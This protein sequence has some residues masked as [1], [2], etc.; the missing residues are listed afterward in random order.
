MPSVRKQEGLRELAWIFLWLGAT[1]FGGSILPLM[2]EAAVRKKQ[3]LSREKFAEAVAL[4][5]L[6]PGP[7]ALKTAAYTGFRVRGMA[8][9]FTAIACFLLPSFLIV[10][11]GALLFFHTGRPP[12]LPKAL[13][14]WVSPVAIGLLLVTT[15]RMGRQFLTGPPQ[16]GLAFLTFFLLSGGASPILVLWGCGLLGIAWHGALSESP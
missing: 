14:F 1:S 4:A 5:E 3:W 2:E 11:A 13:F 6:V 9:A 8:G 7:M 16:W 10:L 15:C 12:S